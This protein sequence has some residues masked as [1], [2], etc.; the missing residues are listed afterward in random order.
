MKK[1][2]ID[3]EGKLLEV[4]LPDE[5]GFYST[6]STFEGMLMEVLERPKDYPILHPEEEY[7]G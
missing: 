7:D 4:I 5:F 2:T 3:W 1:I 6:L